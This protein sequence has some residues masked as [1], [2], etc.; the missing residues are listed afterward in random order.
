MLQLIK[1]SHNLPQLQNF[2]RHC[3]AFGL[4]SDQG[5]W[6][7]FTVIKH[8]Y[9]QELYWFINKYLRTGNFCGVCFD[10]FVST[11]WYDCVIAGPDYIMVSICLTS[12]FRCDSISTNPQHP[13]LIWVHFVAD[14][15]DIAAQEVKG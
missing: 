15:E 3:W 8:G 6:P 5:F 13:A 7:D 10:V 11:V 2:D 12:S 1:I 14:Q 4:L 9:A